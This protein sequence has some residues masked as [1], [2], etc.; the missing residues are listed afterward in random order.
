[1]EDFTWVRELMRAIGYL[2]GG[3]YADTG[4]NKSDWLPGWRILRGHG[5]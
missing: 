4:T 3:F 2:D 1:M 5:N